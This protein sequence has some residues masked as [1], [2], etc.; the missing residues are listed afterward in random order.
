MF[1]EDSIQDQSEDA[2]SAVPKKTQRLGVKTEGVW[3]TRAN[4][5]TPTTSQIK[6]KDE[7]VHED[8]EMIWWVWNGKIVGFSDW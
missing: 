5:G 8:D 4:G 6:E 1:L 3:V 7:S 2:T